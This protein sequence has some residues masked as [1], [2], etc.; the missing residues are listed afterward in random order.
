MNLVK[1]SGCPNCATNRR[2]HIF[3]KSDQTFKSELHNIHL[4]KID[5]LEEYAGNKVSKKIYCCLC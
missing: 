5:S 3:L 4:G 1:K 2:K